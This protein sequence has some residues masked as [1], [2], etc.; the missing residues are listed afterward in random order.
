MVV[1]EM[2]VK[3]KRQNVEKSH[4]L[5]QSDGRVEK[6]I[7]GMSHALELLNRKRII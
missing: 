5:S 4:N 7:Q 1:G 6:G 3:E 2:K